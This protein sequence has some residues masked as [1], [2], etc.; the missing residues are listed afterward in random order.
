GPDPDRV[1]R[2]PFLLTHVEVVVTRGAAPID[3]RG[4][5][6]GHKAPILPEVLPGACAPA[7]VQPVNHRRRNPPRLQYQPRH[8]RRERTA[9]AGGWTNRHNIRPC[10]FHSVHPRRALRRPTTPAMVSPSARAAKAKA[11]R[12]GRT[13]SA[14]ATTSSTEGA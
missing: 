13:G 7:T 4:S 6:T 11:M 1:G 14:T 5:L 2:L 10:C 9:H 8:A 12:C 3:S